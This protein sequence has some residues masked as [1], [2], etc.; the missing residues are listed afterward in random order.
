VELKAEFDSAWKKASE[1][2]LV[3]NGTKNGGYRFLLATGLPSPNPLPSFEEALLGMLR[4]RVLRNNSLVLDLPVPAS[5]IFSAADAPIRLRAKREGDRLSF[6]VN[7]RKPAETRDP[8]AVGMGQREKSFFGVH[9]PLGVGLRRLTANHSELPPRPNELQ[10]GDDLFVQGKYEDALQAYREAAI[11]IKTDEPLV[12]EEARYKEGLCEL[13]SNREEEA[14]RIFEE[15]VSRFLLAGKGSDMSWLFMADCQLLGHFFRQKDG[16]DKAGAVLDRV[17]EYGYTRDQLMLLMPADVQAAILYNNLSGSVG[18]NLNRTPEEHLKRAQFAVDASKVL[19]P[20]GRKVDYKW[21]ALLRAQMA[22]GQTDKAMETAR[23]MFREF[24]DLGDP[25]DDYCWMLRLDG[26]PDEALKF[27]ERGV[28]KDP[29]HLI[30]RSRIHAALGQWGEAQ[31]DLDLYFQKPK[32]Y[33]SFSAAALLHGF[34]LEHQGAGA[35]KIDEA[36][37]RGLMKNWRSTG[38]DKGLDP[39]R[40]DEAPQGMPMMHHWIMASLTG[41]MSDIEA[42]QLLGGLIAFAGKDNPVF[43]KLMRPSVLR[44][45]WRTPRGRDVARQLALRSIPFSEAARYPVF[46]G[47][48]SF[49]HEVC[50]PPEPLTAEQDELLWRMA[51][52]IYDAYRSGLITER[53]LLPFGTIVQG[54]PNAPGMGWK[55]MGKILEGSPR[56]RGPLGYVFGQRYVKKNDLVNARLFYKSAIYDA[57]RDGGDPLLEKLAKAELDRLGTK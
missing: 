5:E 25:L 54:N 12:R 39:L 56:L 23:Q 15:I 55:E 48:I 44:A 57:G 36:W 8:F 30:E 10:K 51:I 9:W 29:A 18:Q 11:K 35:E 49:V 21:H 16:I 40:K 43:N 52:Q 27:I 3:L 32:D 34:L 31:K 46:M 26:K 53:Y 4:M 24:G 41:E 1:I 19:E 45:T 22:A 7:D 47:W 37:K 38:N 13:Q 14:V 17:K 20:P 28:A 33:H 42:E 50:F 6:Q 2:G